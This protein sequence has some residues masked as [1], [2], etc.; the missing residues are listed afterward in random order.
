MARLPL[1][2]QKPT[3]SGLE[4]TYTAANADGFS[5]QTTGEEYLHIKNAG[6]ADRT[7]TAPTPGTSGSGLAIAEATCP[8]TAAEQRFFG[9]F[10]AA[11]F[12]QSDGAVYVNFDDPTG[13]SVA[14]LRVR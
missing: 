4:A 7:A 11:E 9:P 1:T 6:V 5:F 8:I 13:I 14:L 2:A 10:P 3:L 12:V